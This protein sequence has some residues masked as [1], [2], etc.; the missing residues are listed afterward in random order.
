MLILPER[1][2]EDETRLHPADDRGELEGVGGLEF[3]L[4]V[5][6]ERDELDRGAEQLGGAFRLGGALRGC[7]V[8]AGLAAGADDQVHVPA[9]AGFLRDDAADAELEVVWVRAEGEERFR[10]FHGRGC[11]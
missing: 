1:G 8:G 11:L 2:G 6:V 5:A 9:G 4:G 10:G 7:A 3:E